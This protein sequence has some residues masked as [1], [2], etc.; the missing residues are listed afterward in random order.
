MQLPIK[1]AHSELLSV[2]DLKSKVHPQNPKHHPAEQIAS[3]RKILEHQ[4]IRRPVVIS[5][6]SGLIVAGH[7]LLETLVVM[8]CD[9]APVDYQDFATEADELAHMLADNKLAELGQINEAQ[10]SKIIADIEGAGLDRELAGLIAE[11]ET[12]TEIKPVSI[13]PPP[14]MAWA[15]IG[16]PI[17]HFGKVQKV[18]EM[19]P[20]EAKVLTTTNNN[21]GEKIF[22]N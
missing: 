3:F 21:E 10:V 2:K 15:L 12:K 11:L 13:L 7:G 9:K 4:G 22:N 20:G 8:R 5:K 19:L 18:L 1:C 6:R 17:E 16:I 14:T